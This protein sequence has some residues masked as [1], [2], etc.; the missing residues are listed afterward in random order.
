MLPAGISFL[1]NTDQHKIIGLCFSDLILQH[2]RLQL[3]LSMEEHG[4]SL[5]MWWRA[6]SAPSVMHV[7]RFLPVFMFN[8]LN[9]SE[10]Y[11]RYL[12][13]PRVPAGCPGSFQLSWVLGTPARTACCSS[14]LGRSS[15]Y[16]PA[17]GRAAAR[18]PWSA[19]WGGAGDRAFVQWRCLMAWLSEWVQ[20]KG[21]EGEEFGLF[22]NVIWCWTACVNW[23]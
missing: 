19:W 1:V 9:N 13:K 6:G 15:P 17:S 21:G 22:L 2:K 18:S 4:I 3:I 20:R 7:Q 14:S 8:M 10:V 23:K 11:H 5:S 12:P 16:W